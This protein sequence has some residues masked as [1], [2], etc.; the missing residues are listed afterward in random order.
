MFCSQNCAC[1]AA[2]ITVAASFTEILLVLTLNWVLWRTVQKDKLASGKQA[3]VDTARQSADS[4]KTDLQQVSCEDVK[5]CK[6]C[7]SSRQ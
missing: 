3:E 1:Q 7:V 4:C 6:C 5:Q 2:G